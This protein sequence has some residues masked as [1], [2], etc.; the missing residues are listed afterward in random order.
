MLKKFSVAIVVLIGLLYLIY[1]LISTSLEPQYSGTAVLWGLESKSTV[2]FDKYGVPH[3]YAESELDAYR[4]LGYVHA[5]DRLWQMELVRR[6]APGRLSEIFGKDLLSA[7][8]FFKTLGVNLYSEQQVAR[9][10]SEG[11]PNVLNA[12]QAYLDGINAYMHHGPTPIEFIILGI[13]K[14]DFELVDI[15]NVLG[16]MSISFAQAHKTEPVLT[17]IYQKYGVRYLDDL[18]IDGREGTQLMMNHQLSVRCFRFRDRFRQL[19][20][21][22]LLQPLLAAIVGY[23]APPKPNQ[24]GQFLPMILT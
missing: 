9:L 16:Y 21:N 3:I 24:E 20:I 11:D 10:K 12:A 14:R 8:M 7:D 5:Q 18:D 17:Q 15:Y 1:Y 13:E 22:C 6:I 23:W 4:T 19:W 2:Y